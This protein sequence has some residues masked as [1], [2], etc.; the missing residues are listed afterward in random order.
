M[1]MMLH[2]QNTMLALRREMG[3]PPFKPMN[4]CIGFCSGRPMDFE[5]GSEIARIA[6]KLGKDVIYAGWASTKATQPTGFTVAYR[7]MFS[8]DIVD[9]L[10]PFA[11]ND[12]APIVLVST[13]VDE[14]FAI[15]MR[16]S[17]VRLAGKPKNI[18]T[19]RKLATK[20]INATTATLG[21]ELLQNNRFVP[22]GAEWIE[23]ETPIETIVRF[24]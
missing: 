13:R 14:C 4:D 2:H 24:G 21:D 8:V 12:D 3:W 20:R 16:G 11:A 5:T 23:P 19:G 6:H 7:M 17:L 9:R 1:K 22:T 10:V 18:G 15:D